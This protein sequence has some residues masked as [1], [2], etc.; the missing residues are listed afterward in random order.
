VSFDGTDL[1]RAVLTGNP[2]RSEIANAA[3]TTGPD[4]SRHAREALGLPDDRTIIA[5]FTGS[6]GSR[7]VNDAVRGLVARWSDRRDIAIRHV[8]GK[9][10]YADYIE[11]LPTAAEGG[12]VYQ[13]VAYEER[14]DLLLSAADIGVTR[15]GG[16]VAELAALGVPAILV[17]LP[18]ATRDHQTAN[19]RALVAAGAAVMVPDDELTTER[20]RHELDELLT[21]RTRL[22]A[23]AVAMRHCAHLDAAERVADVVERVAS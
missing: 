14:M 18:I 11:N 5:V 8:I 3:R 20:L 21:D 10:D 23:M 4:A 22:D 1:Q 13:C 7:R 16:G 6:L 19:A 2:L 9:R 15:A 12:L 17:P